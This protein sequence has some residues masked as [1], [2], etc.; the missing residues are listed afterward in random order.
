MLQFGDEKQMA[1]L[2]ISKIF[3]P[4]PRSRQVEDVKFSVHLDTVQDKK[5]AVR[6]PKIPTSKKL[7]STISHLLQ[8][9]IQLLSLSLS[10]RCFHHWHIPRLSIREH[11]RTDINQANISNR[12]KI[13]LHQL[14]QDVQGH[15]YLAH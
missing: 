2:N 10:L 13:Q 3:S 9:K 1:I 6:S 5:L 15:L 7:S 11:P 14:I 8:I 12:S 4:G